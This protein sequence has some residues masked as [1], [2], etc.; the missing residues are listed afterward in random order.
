M[1]ELPEVETTRRGIAPHVSGRRITRIRVRD[2][3]LRW[4]V[5]LPKSLA[6]STVTAVERR[7]KYLGLVATDGAIII[8]LGMSG[9]L[10]L[11]EVGSTPAKHDHVD[12]DFDHG[13]ALR[14]T[15]P[16]RFGSIHYQA[17]DWLRHPLLENLGPEPLSED[18]DAAYLFARTRGR[19]VPIKSFIMD[20]RMVVGVGNIYANEA[21]YRAGVRPRR[22]AGRITRAESERLTV[23]IKATLEEAVTAGGTTLR[24]FLGS[25]GTA[26]YFSTQLA[27]Y[28]RQGL[29]CPRCG[30][31]LK[32]VRLG[33]RATAFC[34][35]CQR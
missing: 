23:A 22:A 25:D 10:R 30:M 8:H 26:G 34:P 33:Q 32:G 14:L 17:G 28:G 27:V 13:V 21:L 19:R 31:T 3:R 35:K 20:A 6:G 12:I 15:D 11:V 2:G 1:P 7:A 16:R 18:F 24:D 5:R 4:P 29:P 9:H